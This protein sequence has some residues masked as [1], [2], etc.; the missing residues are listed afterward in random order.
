MKQRSNT[1]KNISAD[2]SKVGSLCG[3][4]PQSLIS[5]G[6]TIRL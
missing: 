2:G 4:E 3:I 1:V 6:L 5:E